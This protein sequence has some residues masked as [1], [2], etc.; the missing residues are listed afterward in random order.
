[1]KKAIVGILAVIV[2]VAAVMMYGGYIEEEISIPEINPPSFVS[3]TKCLYVGLEI[4]EK[5]GENTAT[6]VGRDGIC[7]PDVIDR[8]IVWDSKGIAE[9]HIVTKKE[10]LIIKRG[11]PTENQPRFMDI[12]C[13]GM[14]YFDTY[15]ECEDYMQRHR[16]K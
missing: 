10:T 12:D 8:V 16:R 1:M 7:Y 6:F 13:D 9:L 15:K 11:S 2:V 3:D 5:T 14:R 4:W